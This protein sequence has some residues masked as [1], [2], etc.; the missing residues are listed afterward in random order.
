MPTY[1][2][3]IIETGDQFEVVQSIK[4]DPYEEIKEEK[5][6]KTLKVRRL[7]S[8]GSGVIFKGEGWTKPP[9]CKEKPKINPDKILNKELKKAD[10]TSSEKLK[11]D[12]EFTDWV[13]SG[14]L[15]KIPP[16]KLK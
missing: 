8:G 14:G 9:V 4:D 13:N 2:Y 5:T 3:E 12:K 6:G 7:I 15:D 16:T 11:K 1:V 10:N